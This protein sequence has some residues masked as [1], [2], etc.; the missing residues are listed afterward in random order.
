MATDKLDSGSLLLHL[1]VLK[2][3]LVTAHY[4][5]LKEPSLKDDWKRDSLAIDGA[6]GILIFLSV[7]AAVGCLLWVSRK[8]KRPSQRLPSAKLQP[9]VDGVQL[10]DQQLPPVK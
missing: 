2:V 1:N 4:R 10:K 8:F 9:D 7:S 5:N 3:K 6:L